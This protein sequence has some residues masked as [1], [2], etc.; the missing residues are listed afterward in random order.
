MTIREKIILS[1]ALLMSAGYVVYYFSH[2]FVS[3]MSDPRPAE[4]E[5]VS[6]FIDKMNI[7]LRE[8]VLS[9]A[10]QYVIGNEFSKWPDPFPLPPVADGLIEPEPVK[11]GFRPLYSGF[12]ESG[13]RRIAILDHMEYEI[14][15]RIAGSNYHV[16]NI[17]PEYAEIGIKG[18][19]NF[20]VKMT[21]NE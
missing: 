21:E 2:S 11:H 15:D 5:S 3:K 20:I 7:R 18:K 13:G 4:E 19:K 8:S 10:E 1:L 6:A 12:L 14:G 9:A 16:V 17:L